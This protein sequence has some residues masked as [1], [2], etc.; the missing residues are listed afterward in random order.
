MNMVDLPSPIFERIVDEVYADRTIAPHA[1]LLS[2][3]FV[4]PVRQTL[5]QDLALRS[6]KRTQ[7]LVDLLASDPSLGASCRS[8]AVRP[9]VLIDDTEP[10]AADQLNRVL[11]TVTRVHTLILHFDHGFLRA[12]SPGALRCLAQ[13]HLEN[14]LLTSVDGAESPEVFELLG[15]LGPRLRVVFMRRVRGLA[16][17]RVKGISSMGAFDLLLEAMAVADEVA[18]IGTCRPARLRCE[19]GDATLSQLSEELCYGLRALDLLYGRE[20]SD[21]QL[22]RFVRLE[23]LVLPAFHPSPS[24]DALPVTLTCLAVC[25]GD[26]IS[27]LARRLL[28]RAFLPNL[29]RIQG[30]FG[31][32]RGGVGRDVEVQAAALSRC[33]RRHFA[34]EFEGICQAR[35]ITT[36]LP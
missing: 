20:V 33:N 26:G 32:E 18:V 16:T 9:S 23:H 3:A 2:R 4:R 15:A 28:D 14:L 11:A 6:R 30:R 5:I 34:R 7:S 27:T 12:L 36:T 13:A 22:R 19:G 17:A 1:L 29:K 31:G 24:E 8:I 21:A 10:M 25:R 35:G